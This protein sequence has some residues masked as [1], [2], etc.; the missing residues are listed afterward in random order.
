VVRLRSDISEAVLSRSLGNQPGFTDHLINLLF[1]AKLLTKIGHNVAK[2]S[3]GDEII[4]VLV[5]CLEG[6]LRAIIFNYSGKLV[7]PLPSASIWGIG[8]RDKL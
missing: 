3:G 6:M 4:S 2:L 5:K 8:K 1:V 7:V